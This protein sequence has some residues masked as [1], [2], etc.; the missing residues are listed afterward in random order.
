[1]T[2]VPTKLILWTG[3]KHSGKTTGAFKL[4][5]TVRNEG[6]TVAGLLA[7]S[8]YDNDK[9]IGF[10]AFD[11]QSENRAPLARRRIE[12]NPAMNCGA[13][14]LAPRFT[15]GLRQSFADLL[16]DGIKL[17]NAAL[18]PIATSS[19]DLIIVDEFGPLE[20]DSRG[21]RKNIDSLLASSNG[22]IL[23]VVRQELINAVKQLY[24]AIPSREIMASEPTSFAQIIALLKNG[25]QGKLE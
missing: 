17:G 11:L 1:M 5:E 21:W 8:L 6:F 16:P 2:L 3:K 24:R 15:R 9:L 12:T 4:V 25:R 23:L 13:K 7:L 22:V 19:A 18:N 20:L 14:Y 10:D